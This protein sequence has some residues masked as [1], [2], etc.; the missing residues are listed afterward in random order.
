MVSKKVE[1]DSLSMNEGSKPTKW[2]C[3]GET[4]YEFTES[5]LNK[6]IKTRP[7]MSFF[8]YGRKYGNNKRNAFMKILVIVVKNVVRLQILLIVAR[9]PK[10]LVNL[11]IYVYYDY[12]PVEQKSNDQSMFFHQNTH[13]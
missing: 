9:N 12:R 8:L 3:E 5:S 10:V 7:K 2:I 13:S 4:D 1:V 6:V 11:Q